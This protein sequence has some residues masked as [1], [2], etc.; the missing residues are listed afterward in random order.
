MYRKYAKIK[1][2][3]Y[4]QFSIYNFI[5]IISGVFLV[6]LT[7]GIRNMSLNKIEDQV[8]FNESS[9]LIQSKV[10]SS[11]YP[12]G[13]DINDDDVVELSNFFDNVSVINLTE[14][15]SQTSQN[16]K[17]Y[18]TNNQFIHTGV[19]TIDYDYTKTIVQDL[20]LLYGNIWNEDTTSNVVVIDETTAL[21]VFGYVDAVGNS[22]STSV[23]DLEIIGVVSDTITRNQLMQKAIEAGQN[24]DNFVYATNAYVPIGYFETLNV[25][26]DEIQNI[27]VQ[28]SDYTAEQLKIEVSKVMSISDINILNT[29]YDMIQAQVMSNEIYF[30]ILILLISVFSTLGLINLINVTS[31][32]YSI[33]K[34]NLA[35]YRVLGAS[36]FDMIKIASIEGFYLG[37]IGTICAVLLSGLMLI[38]VS[39]PMGSTRYIS[40]LYLLRI[41]FYISAIIIFLM[42]VVNV[43]VLLVNFKKMFNDDLRGEKL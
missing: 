22:L 21:N 38:I 15:N 14:I 1:L 43:V 4:K 26:D 32:Y 39:I 28:D 20:N 7:L 27:V 30:T 8:V 25:E 11:L 36:R 24:I 34:K 40:I 41:G 37:F 12:E 2:T 13:L 31:F 5:F 6:C 29:R 10:S 33:F 19:V 16:I 18:A 35:I 9:V 17:F 42:M 3:S 23:G